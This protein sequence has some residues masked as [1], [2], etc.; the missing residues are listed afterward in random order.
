MNDTGNKIWFA[1]D[2]LADTDAAEAIEFAL[3]ELD[4]LGTEIDSLRKK[5]GEPQIITGFFAELPTAGQVADAIE[6]SL[7]IHGLESVCRQEC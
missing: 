3:N 5:K 6:G 2:I 7:R 4:S 1:V